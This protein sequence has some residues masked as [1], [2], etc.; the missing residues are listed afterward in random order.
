MINVKSS[1]VN[2]VVTMCY[3]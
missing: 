3:R 1:Q 2:D